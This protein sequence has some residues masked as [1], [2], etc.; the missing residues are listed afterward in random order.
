MIPLSPLDGVTVTSMAPVTGSST[1]FSTRMP[2]GCPRREWL[3]GIEVGVKA[4]L[5][6]APG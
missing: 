4:L 3:L 6:V 5:P 2:V 1:M